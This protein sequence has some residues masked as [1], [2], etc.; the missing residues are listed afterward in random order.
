MLPGEK[1]LRMKNTMIAIVL[2]GLGA[3]VGAQAPQKPVPATPI[4][5]LFAKTGL[6]ALQA[7]DDFKGTGSLSGTAKDA[8][9]AARVE[10]T[11]TSTLRP[12]CLRT[13][14]ILQSCARPIMLPAKTL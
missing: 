8:L 12:L 13:C 14:S 11:S 4:S 5:D 7:I 6:K 1:L 3:P 10:A 2:V 9:E